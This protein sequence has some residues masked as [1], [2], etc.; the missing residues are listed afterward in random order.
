MK[1]LQKGFTL[2]ELMIVIAIIGILAAIAVP[3]YSDYIARS[4]ASEASS[5]AAGLKTQV[6]DNMQNNQ[7]V[8]GPNNTLVA[9]IDQQEGKYGVAVI[10]GTA[11]VNQ[12]ALQPNDPTGC[13]ITYTVN[14]NG[15]S[16]SIAGQALVLDVLKNGSVH[17][18]NSSTMDDKYIPKAYL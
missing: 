2:I 4:Q 12:A 11:E 14:A 17:K 18:N 8:S 7:C 5:L 15:V 1:A 16:A 13:T 9:N 6:V 3:A 10:G